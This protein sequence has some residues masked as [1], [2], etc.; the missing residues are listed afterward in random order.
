VLA[1]LPGLKKIIVR[2]AAACRAGD[3]Y[4]TWADFS[5]LG[6]QRLAATPGGVAGRVAAIR[7]EDPVTVLY[8]SGTTG[9]PKGVIITHRSV[10]CQLA[11]AGAAGFMMERVRLV[12]Y[13]PL[14]HI[15]ERMSAIYGRV[16]NAGHVYFCRNAA[17]LAR[18]PA[19]LA[20][21]TE[22]VA[23]ANERLARVQQV[24][25]WRLLPAEWTAESEELTPTFKLR[26]R[27]VHAKYADVI[28]ALYA[29]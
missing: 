13:L 15:A 24:R 1:R 16:H 14:A 17:E 3:Q 12:S 26:R 18:E 22:A 28:D 23:D 19:V 2:D 10:L 6:R 27:V 21:V 8:T 20:A 25:R 7:S 9:N 5:A 11:A 29:D 4:L